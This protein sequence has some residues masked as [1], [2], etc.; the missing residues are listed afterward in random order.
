MQTKRR[1]RHGLATIE[2]AMFLPLFAVFI[3][4]FLAMG[5]AGDT[6]IS[7]A[8]Q[9]RAEAFDQ[10]DGKSQSKALRWPTTDFK[11]EL[12]FGVGSKS[13]DA[14]GRMG[15]WGPIETRLAI[16]D[17]PWD[18]RTIEF[19]KLF[20]Q[21]KYTATLSS[22]PNA[23]LNAA[24]GKL[25]EVK[26]AISNPGAALADSINKNKAS[27]KK[28]TDDAADSV[29]KAEKKI[30]EERKVEQDRLDA[31]H[32]TLQDEYAAKESRLAG[33]I[34]AAD[35][36]EKTQAE[37]AAK[38]LIENDKEILRL[39]GEA[40]AR[41]SKPSLLR[42]RKDILA[43]FGSKAD[44][45]NALSGNAAEIDRKMKGNRKAREALK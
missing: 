14:G 30:E 24:M 9:A 45:A 12:E 15:T 28:A 42:K 16:L 11:S 41:F 7:V 21:E 6:A 19:K 31:E 23:G 33:L 3:M 34:E 36:N 10:R 1:T 38:D 32:G 22:L 26:Q 40:A 20:D 35:E 29:V 43:R 37:K 39:G 27:W 8:V 13:V 17:N 25:D 2:L 5:K 44:R 4:F 18:Y